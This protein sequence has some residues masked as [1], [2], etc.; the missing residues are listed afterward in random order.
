MQLDID[1]LI[2]GS[3][4]AGLLCQRRLNEMGK[5]SII[6]DRVSHNRFASRDYLITTFKKFDFS[7]DPISLK[8]VMIASGCA[9]FEAEF[10]RKVYNQEFSI[11]PYHN[12]DS[13]AY[14]IDDKLITEGSRIYGNME[15]THIDQRSRIAYGKVL[16]LDSSFKIS[17]NKLISTIPINQFQKLI[18]SKFLDMFDLFLSYYPTGIRKEVAH[19]K[20]DDILV[21]YYA[22]M[23]IPFCR[24]YYSGN[25]VFYEYCINKKHDVKFD[26]V[27]NPGRFIPPER[28]KIEHFYKYFV[29]YDIYFAGRYALWDPSFLLQNIIDPIDT[30]SNLYMNEAFR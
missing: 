26:F 24:K 30:L 29:E 25:T 16:H 19:E 10:S 22:D 7:K 6:I 1:Y 20:R 9:P 28:E 2:I 14:P 5:K 11:N 8:K 3:G 21:E 27:I 15:I 23:N 12:S 4:Y 18:P 13:Q 17:Y